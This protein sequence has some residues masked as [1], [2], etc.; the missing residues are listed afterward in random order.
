MN[1]KIIIMQKYATKIADDAAILSQK[2]QNLNELCAPT[3]INVGVDPFLH[4]ITLFILA[5]FIGYY[6]VWRVLPSLHTPLMALTNAISGIV[7]IGAMIAMG[8]EGF[9]LA[10]FVGFFAVILAAINIF[11][12]FIVTHRM[13]NMFRKK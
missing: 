10:Q 8:K 11:G 4:A 7:I 1:D 2:M 3:T 6:V 9:G 5:C 13:L 12:G